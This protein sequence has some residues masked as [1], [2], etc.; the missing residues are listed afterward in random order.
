MRRIKRHA[1]RSPWF[2]SSTLVHTSVV[3]AFLLL[4][5]SSAPM[6]VSAGISSEA[7]E[8]QTNAERRAAGLPALR[9]DP[10]LA[11]VAKMRAEEIVASSRFDHVRPD[12]T[13][14]ATIIPQHQYERVGENLAID[15]LRDA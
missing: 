1:I 5:L 6:A 14:F 13:S 12:G 7:I 4:F 2:R 10:L 3:C 8:V 11:H 15:F 9:H